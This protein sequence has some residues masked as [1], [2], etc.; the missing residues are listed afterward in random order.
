MCSLFFFILLSN[1]CILPP[2][3]IFLIWFSYNLVVPSS[4]PHCNC[5]PCIPRPI[6]LVLWLLAP[7]SL[8]L[9]SFL[10]IS[11]FLVDN[12]SYSLNTLTFELYQPI[13]LTSTCLGCPIICH[14]QK[15]QPIHNFICI[16][17]SL[18]IIFLIYFFYFQ[19]PKYFYFTKKSKQLIQPIFSV[20]YPFDVLII[21]LPIFLYSVSNPYSYFLI[22]NIPLTEWLLLVL[23]VWQDHNLVK[24]RS[25]F[26]MPTV[27]QLNI[28]RRNT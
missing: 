21:P 26:S 28:G 4:I 2:P 20:L 24:F 7:G 18:I 16:C 11:I 27:L 3:S 22:Y 14:Y 8:S 12:S 25:L 6:I 13:I 15:L 17:S 23:F 9:F 19:T 5:Y 1:Q 10:V